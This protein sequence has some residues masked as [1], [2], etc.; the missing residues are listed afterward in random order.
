[1]AGERKTGILH[2]ITETKVNDVICPKCGEI[3]GIEFVPAVDGYF[4]NAIRNYEAK[5]SSMRTFLTRIERCL[6]CPY[7]GKNF[8]KGENEDDGASLIALGITLQGGSL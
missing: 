3:F 2:R 4:H 1:M 7:Y 8:W 5:K 6:K